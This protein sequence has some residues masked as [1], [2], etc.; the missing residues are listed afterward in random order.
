MSEPRPGSFVPQPGSWTVS[1]G[2]AELL[3]DADRPGAFLLAVDGVAQSY[4][5][6]VDPTHVEFGYV[7]V[8]AAVVDALAPPTPAPIAVVHVGGGAAT[9]ARRIAVM[10]PGSAQT[11]IEADE[12]LARGVEERLGTAGFTFRLGDGRGEVAWLPADTAAG[13]VTDA[14]V[15]S[16]VPPP[17]TTREYLQDV[18]RVLNVDGWYAVNV[19][20]AHPFAYA[21]RVVATVDEVFARCLLVAEPGVL[22]GRRFGNVICVGSDRALPEGDLVRAVAA[23]AASPNRVVA[24]DDLHEFLAGAAPLRDE[25]DMPSPTPPP[26]AFSI[27]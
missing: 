14:F 1:G 10:R 18:R 26:G 25:D 22:R 15:G 9:L 24:G 2:E 5:D 3:A 4:V 13:L 6:L 20:D 11:V 19:A 21:R 27:R 8:L 16:A 17:L 7:R 23:D 12:A